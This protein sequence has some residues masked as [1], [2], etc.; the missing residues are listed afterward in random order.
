MASTGSGGDVSETE[1]EKGRRL[2]KEREED[3]AAAKTAEEAIERLGIFR[4]GF[5][6][7]LMEADSLEAKRT[8]VTDLIRAHYSTRSAN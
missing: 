7:R 1:S 2:D 8:E 5:T 6:Q 3:T 4:A